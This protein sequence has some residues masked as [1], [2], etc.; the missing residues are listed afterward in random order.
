MTHT[1]L[2]MTVLAIALASAL[3]ALSVAHATADQ[4]TATFST[5]NLA[6]ARA[7]R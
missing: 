2:R 3:A 1:I 6:L 5:L 7:V 4:L